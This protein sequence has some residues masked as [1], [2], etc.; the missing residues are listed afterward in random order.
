MGT[1]TD[2]FDPPATRSKRFAR[3]LLTL[4]E[5]CLGLLMP[6]TLARIALVTALAW[7]MVASSRAQSAP[8]LPIEPA[9]EAAAERVVL[10]ESVSD[11]IEPFNRGIY[12]FNNGILTGL[13]KPTAKVYRHIVIKPVRTGIANFGRNITFPGRLI[14]NL[15]QGKWDGAR[16]ETYRFGCNTTFGVAGFM[17]VASKWKIPK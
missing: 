14:N 15:L 17:D 4:G 5:N 1:A 7:A 3:R 9:S 13:V 2:G 8:A 6:E 11:P 12:A 16:D 10:P